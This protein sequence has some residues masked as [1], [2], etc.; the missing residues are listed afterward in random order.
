MSPYTSSRNRR[1]FVRDL[2]V[3]G[4]AVF[5]GTALGSCDNRN[6]THRHAMISP[7]TPGQGVD[8]GAESDASGRLS[9]PG[10]T[11][12]NTWSVWSDS[13][14]S[15]DTPWRSGLWRTGARPSGRCGVV[16]GAPEPDKTVAKPR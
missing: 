5:A 15:P 4:G 7:V 16:A 6:L 2:A 8:E 11:K 10:L 14:D 3:A 1:A 13:S 12:S 9:E